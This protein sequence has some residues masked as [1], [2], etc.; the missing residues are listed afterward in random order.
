MEAFLDEMLLI[1][2]V[3]GLSAFETPKERQSVYVPTDSLPNSTESDEATRVQSPSRQ[4]KP[5]QPSRAIRG[6]EALELR[7]PHGVEG[8]GAYRSEGFVVFEGSTARAE[9]VP[10][11]HDFLA[12]L[13]EELEQQGVL[14]RE[15]DRL[16]FVR[17]YVFD[18]PSSAAGVLLGRSANG[19][20][21]WSDEDGRTLKAIQEEALNAPAQP[22]EPSAAK[23]TQPSS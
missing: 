9:S 4:I 15:G 3:V 18:S 11:I 17:P 8:K 23:S 1:L 12:R 7:G 13:R 21:E 22:A 16:R 5:V 14:I 19:R 6:M 2:P 10:S 20:I